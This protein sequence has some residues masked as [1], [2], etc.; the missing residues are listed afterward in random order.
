[1]ARSED[2]NSVHE[3]PKFGNSTTLIE[4]VII[5]SKRIVNMSATLW[6]TKLGARLDVIAG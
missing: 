2:H 1:M 6:E 5:L 4:F 3:T